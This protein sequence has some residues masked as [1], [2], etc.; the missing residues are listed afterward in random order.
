MT[1]RFIWAL[2][3]AFVVSLTALAGLGY[4]V[5]RLRL[6]LSPQPTIYRNIFFEL[7]LANGWT[8]RQDGTEQVCFPDQT[9]P[10]AAIAVIAMKYRNKDDNLAAYE[11]HLKQPQ[12]SNDQNPPSEVRSVKRSMIGEREWVESLHVGSEIPNYLTYYAATAT[13]HV[14]ILVTMSVHKDRADRYIKE[15]GE[16]LKTM[17]TYQRG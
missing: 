14:G 17:R 6:A 12:K 4:G 15:F 13:S 7:D 5:S 1:T 3:L 9:K 11:K 16:M 10:H 8:C 2:L